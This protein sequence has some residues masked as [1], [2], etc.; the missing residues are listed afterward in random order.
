M[1]ARSNLA[2]IILPDDAELDDP[3]RD[4]SHLQG[5]AVFRVFLEQ[6]RVF[7]GGSEFCRVID[8]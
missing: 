4:R 5:L 7:E 1:Q 2:L 6:S 3:L 8:C